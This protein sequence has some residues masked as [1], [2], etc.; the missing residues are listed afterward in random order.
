MPRVSPLNSQV[1][2][3]LQVS[4]ILLYIADVS[5]G[6]HRSCLDQG[7]LLAAIEEI[8][9]VDA[10]RPPVSEAL[11]ANARKRIHEAFSDLMGNIGRTMEMNLSEVIDPLTSFRDVDEGVDFGSPDSASLVT[12]L[13]AR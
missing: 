10:V 4:G 2:F 12:R 9:G 13:R 1:A 3:R 5:E 6:F 11:V 7:A 8:I